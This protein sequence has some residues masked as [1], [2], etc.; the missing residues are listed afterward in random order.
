MHYE[1]WGMGESVESVFKDKVLG[2]TNESSE[3]RAKGE[4]HSFKI[5]ERP[6]GLS[7][8]KF[9]DAVIAVATDDRALRKVR[10]DAQSAVRAAATEYLDESGS[11]IAIEPSYIEKKNYKEQQQAA[12]SRA[13]VYLFFGKA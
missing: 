11:V 10:E 2:D 7:A 9:V 5:I 6:K 12:R 1:V 13:Q 3:F 8:R 4:A